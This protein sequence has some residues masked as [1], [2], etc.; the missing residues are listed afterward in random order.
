MIKK[1]WY[2]W[3]VYQ[4]MQATCFIFGGIEG[5]EYVY[6][7][8]GHVHVYFTIE[9]TCYSFKMFVVLEVLF[10]WKSFDFY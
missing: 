9:S 8:S 3:L 7:I 10:G 2:F 1:S 6:E 5:H 4:F